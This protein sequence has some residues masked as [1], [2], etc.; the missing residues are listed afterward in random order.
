MVQKHIVQNYLV[1]MV[2]SCCMVE[3]GYDG[4]VFS[5]IQ[6]LPT[7]VEYF[8]NPNP[9]LVG[10]INT[11]YS[12]CAIVFGFFISPI[13][14]DRLG[15]KWAL[16]AGSAL[17]VV[18]TFVMTFAPNIAAFI[19]GRAIAG[20]GQGLAMPVG[21]IYIEEL[22]YSRTRGRLMSI[23][24]IFY[25]IG[26]KIATY[27]ALGCVY[28]PHL[29]IWQFR[30]V[31]IFQLFAPMVL[32]LAL[33]FCPE[34][35]R[36]CV[37]NGRI[38]QAR[39]ALRRVRLEEEV[40]DEL[41]EIRAAVLYE[42]EKTKGS[43]KQLIVNKSYRK[44]LILAIIMNIGQ[45]FSGIGALSQYSGIITEQ[46]FPNPKTVILVKAVVAICITMCPFIAFFFIDKIG[47]RP[48]FIITA[49]GMAGVTFTI[50]TVTT[51]TAT[52][53]RK[54]SLGTGIG[55]TILEICYYA[56]YGP[57]WGAG[58]W[59]W[60]SE[61]WPVVVRA[62]AVAISSQSQQ[63][64]NIVL[65]QAYPSFLAAAGFYT[66]YFFMG[67]NLIM[68]AFCYLFIAETKGISLEHMDTVF[69]SIDHVVAGEQEIM[70]GGKVI[71]ENETV[72][73]TKVADPI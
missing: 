57:G 60:T 32:L 17:V 48:M 8:N 12:V 28:S 45:Q 63:V 25:G 27:I 3:F 55:F 59:I 51:Q 68:A 20:A 21:T 35:P 29:G 37:Q 16:G 9:N 1:A 5:S 46:V 69:G 42:Q 4:T 36:W 19:G 40:E 11:A 56:F 61:I 54:H 49:L 44:R 62:N 2:A 13:I 50:A 52:P 24:Q 18:A 47:R 39:E 72:E 7:W 66:F 6:V 15:R 58:L 23:W 53:D 34:T 31:I 33:P 43:Y 10:A 41:N 65:G 30:T 64:A 26:N 73:D 38:E 22:V 71:H 70:E 67:C 14:A